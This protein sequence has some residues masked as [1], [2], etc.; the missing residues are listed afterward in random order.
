MR[1]NAPGTVP[2]YRGPFMCLFS[3]YILIVTCICVFTRNSII[4]KT[5]MLEQLSKCYIY[6][7]GLYMAIGETS[8]YKI[9]FPILMRSF[10]T[11]ENV[12]VLSKELNFAITE[13]L[14]G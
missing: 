13:Y 8:L 12:S 10:R 1:L 5:A 3:L 11:G 6:L 7:M 9:K 14:Q 2:E 4:R